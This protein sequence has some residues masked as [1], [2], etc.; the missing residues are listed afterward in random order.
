[1]QAC[2][3]CY[4]NANQFVNFACNHKICIECFDFPNTKS[5]LPACLVCKRYKE[6]TGFY[7][8]H[9]VQICTLK[10]KFTIGLDLNETDSVDLRKM[11]FLMGEAPI[12]Q[13]KLILNG[14]RLDA[15]YIPDLA[16]AGVK[17]G[18]SIWLCLKL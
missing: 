13:T 4:E 2:P 15:A 16:E 11:C 8:P 7:G 5:Q 10:R 9:Q 3:L 17:S 18:D 12:C 14:A 1:M 6:I